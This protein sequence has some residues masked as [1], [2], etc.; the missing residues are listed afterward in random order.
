MS[1]YAQSVSDGQYRVSMI[2]KQ[3]AKLCNLSSMVSHRLRPWVSRQI[4]LV[5][6]RCATFDGDATFHTVV[7]LQGNGQEEQC[8]SSLLRAV[9]TKES[10][11]H[12]C[13]HGNC[14]VQY[15][16]PRRI[17]LLFSFCI[18]VAVACLNFGRLGLAA[19]THLLS[20]CQSIIAEKRI[21]MCLR[22]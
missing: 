10:N 4:V 11:N 7:K 5:E 22:C 2:E 17:I 15:N 18:R 6:R 19:R 12:K 16:F 13:T 1:R 14:I 8:V 21:P 20:G 9:A 3:E